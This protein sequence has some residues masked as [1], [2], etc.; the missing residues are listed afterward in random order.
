MA[1]IVF[2][3]SNHGGAG[4]LGTTLRDHGYKLEYRRPDVHGTDPNR[5][6]PPDLNNVHGVII[7]GGPQYVTDTEKT[8][9]LAAECAF[10]KTAHE[11]GLP[12]IGICLGAQMIA[13]ALGGSVDW[14]ERPALGMLKL[15]LNVP[16][17]TETIFNGISWEHPQFFSC[18][19]EVK[20]LPAGAT[21]LASAPSTANAAFK[22]G[23]RTY[24]FQFHPECDK[25]MLAA[26]SADSC[27]VMEKAGTSQSDID[28]QFDRD[29]DL[30]ARSS[31][32]LCVNIATYCLP[33][34]ARVR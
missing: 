13:Q 10:V 34:A 3:H 2:Q 31:D 29:Y 25:P 7:L 20:K 17:Q 22:V 1:I 4:R 5:G 12:V 26:L 16:G 28:A 23:L 14:K 15:S 32:R 21:V 18:S 27:A 6:V 33:F 9:W 11:A 24:A 30:Y 19:Q 8:P